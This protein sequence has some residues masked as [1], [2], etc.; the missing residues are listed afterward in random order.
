MISTKWNIFADSQATLAA[1]GWRLQGIVPLQDIRRIINTS[2][3]IAF[4]HFK[5]TAV[6]YLQYVS[7]GHVKFI[8][9]PSTTFL[10]KAKK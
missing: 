3:G 6:S 7:L 2:P 8:F 9:F 1:V 10:P 4:V 5:I